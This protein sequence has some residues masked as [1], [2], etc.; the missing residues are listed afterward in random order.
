MSEKSVVHLSEISHRYADN[1]ALSSISLDIPA[2]LRVGFIGPDGVGKS[3]LLGLIS[4]VK[5]A[6]S[7]QCI[8]LDTDIQDDHQRKQICS[9]IAYMP[10]GL[11]KNLYMTLSVY[12]NLLFFAR[13]FNLTK[14]QRQQR[15]DM[16]L[17]ST[18]LT[19][20]HD[21]PAGQLSGGMKQ[22]LGLCCALIH[23]PD[24]L[25]LDEPTTGV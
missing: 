14:Q 2:G 11:G 15:I 21:R 24:L 7:G 22:K 8:V 20:F 3:T 4:G 1:Q 25:I 23:N 9:R 17:R 19:A 6:Q 5:K 18:G 12:E 16:L 13:L 10:Q